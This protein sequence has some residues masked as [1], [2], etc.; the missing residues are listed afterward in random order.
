MRLAVI[1]DY[2]DAFRG[3]DAFRKLQGVELE[4]FHDAAASED[5]LVRRLG[6]VDAVILTQQ[7]TAMPRSVIERLPNLK[8]ISQTGRNTAHIAMTACHER[9]I[10]VCAGGGG[11]RK[12]TRLNSSHEV[13]SR[14]PS[15][16]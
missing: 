2:Q 16:A 5:E 6:A 8:M 1:D 12:S 7:R 15:S 9:G 4:V 14:M 10:V 13:P 3:L 11:D